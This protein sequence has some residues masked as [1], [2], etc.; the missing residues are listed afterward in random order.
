MEKVNIHGLMGI[1]WKV[2]LL[3]GKFKEME[4]LLPFWKTKLT[5][6]NIWME[7]S[8]DKV[9]I[10]GK[11][12]IHIKEI[13]MKIKLVGLEPF[14]LQMEIGIVENSIMGSKMEMVLFIIIMEIIIKEGFWWEINT[15]M[16]LMFS[17]MEVFC[18]SIILFNLLMVNNRLK[19]LFLFEIF[20]SIFCLVFFFFCVLL[21]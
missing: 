1:I 4:F 19:I 15:R 7:K 14:F 11:M 12:E 17:K 13:F 10:Y 6:G 9:L 16:E 21:F 5:L 2:I 20:I 3:M 18:K 8:M